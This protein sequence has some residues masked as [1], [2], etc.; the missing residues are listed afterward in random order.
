[1]KKSY[2]RLESERRG[3]EFCAS[4]S[5]EQWLEIQRKLLELQYSPLWTEPPQDVKDSYRFGWMR[6]M[7]LMIETML[8]GR[9]YAWLSILA[10]GSYQDGDMPKNPV[11][12]SPIMNTPAYKMLT[13]CMDRVYHRGYRITDFIEWIGYALGISYCKRPSI[14]DSL[15]EELYREFSLDLLFLEPTDVLSTFVA[16][17]GQKGH[18]DYFPTPIQVTEAINMMLNSSPTD[19]QFEPCIGGAAM[20]LPSNCLNLVGADLSLTMVKVAC[21][22][23]FLFL[24]SLL[25]VPKPIMG[26]HIN[27]ETKTIHRYFEFNTDTRIYWGN[28]LLGEYRA[29]I[30]IFEEE[31]KQIDI[32]VHPVDLRKRE[33]FQYEED[34]HQPWNSLS[35]DRKIQIIKAHAREIKFECITTNPPFNAKLSRSEAEIIRQLVE[36]NQKFLEERQQRLASYRIS[37]HHVC[38]TAVYEVEL[39]MAEFK[40][41]KVIEGQMEFSLF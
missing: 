24:P 29:P 19:S 18:L 5:P 41:R 23:A 4:L 28:S 26:L 16:E 39:K 12:S 35:D 33:I 11:R 21:I 32:F 40:S 8:Y 22:Q 6:G 34:L 7:G 1:M 27:P 37:S 17:H 2:G 10:K 9:W 20:V 36:S 15:W 31:S 3:Q 25:Y 30:R 14:P 13:K 38:E